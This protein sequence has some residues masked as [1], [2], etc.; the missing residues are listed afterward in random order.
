MK[1]KI[2]FYSYTLFKKIGEEKWLW[3]DAEVN[4]SHGPLH[5]QYL[6]EIQ[7]KKR[8]SEKCHIFACFRLEMLYRFSGAFRRL[9]EL[10]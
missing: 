8:S 4:D 6:I 7:K 2:R 5:E 10:F 1:K 3:V 9:Q